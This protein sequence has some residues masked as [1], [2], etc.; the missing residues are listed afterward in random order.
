MEAALPFPPP[1]PAMA[2]SVCLAMAGTQS[3]RA[4]CFCRAGHKWVLVLDEGKRKGAG[5]RAA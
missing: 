1:T 2:I 5:G 3:K 4:A